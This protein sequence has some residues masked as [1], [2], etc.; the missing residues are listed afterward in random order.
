MTL[1]LEASGETREDIVARLRQALD[2]IELD[3]ED[4]SQGDELTFMLDD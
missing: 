4:E 2:M 3:G 1:T